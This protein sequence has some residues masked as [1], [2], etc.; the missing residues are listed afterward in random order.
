[1]SHRTAAS[2]QP[3]LAERVLLWSFALMVA[4]A[5]VAPVR[6]A[7]VMIDTLTIRLRDD[8]LPAGALRLSAAQRAALGAVLRNSVTENGRTRDGALRLTLAHPV[9]FMEA[10]AA[11]NRVR[12]QPEVLYASVTASDQAML[13]KAL[14]AAPANT[15]QPIT[16]MIVK[17]RDPAL[18]AASYRNGVLP[19]AALSRLAQAT[20]K[21]VAH[22]RA[23][24]GGAW[25][26]KLFQAV[27]MAE[28]QALA[29]LIE[30]DP[31]V[32]YAEPD[33]PMYPMLAPND[34]NFAV[35]Q[36]D[37]QPAGTSPGGANLPA[38]WDIT[39][40]SASIVVADLD[41]GILP[42]PDLAGRT[43]AGYDMISSSTTG[44]DGNGRDSDPTDPGDWVV[45]NECFSGSAASNSSWHGTHTAGTI[46]AAT[47]NAVGI[48]GVN[49]VSKI[50]AVRV[51]GKCCG[52]LADIADAIVWASGGSVAGAPDNATPARVINMS[53]GGSGVCGATYQNAINTALANG[54]VIAVSAGNGNTLTDNQRPANCS[55][56]ITVASVGRNGNRAYYSNYD[57]GAAP[58][59]VEIAAPGGEQSFSNDPNGVLSTLNAG[60]TVAAAYNYVYYQGTSMAAP[61]VTG[62][63]SLMLSANPALTP[64]QVLSK[65]QTSARAFPTGTVRDCTANLAAVTSTIKYCGAGIVDAA[66]AVL[67]A[68]GGAT[69]TTTTLGSSP[70]PSTFG[71][72]VTFTATV[73]GTN[74]TGTVNFKDGASSIAS[75]GAQTVSGAGNSRTAVCITSAL[76]VGTHSVTATYSG[77]A[78]NQTSTSAPPLSQVVNSAGGQTN[79]ALASVGAVAS[80]SST[81]N[82]NYPVAAVNNGDR[83]SASWGAGG[84]WND[85]TVGVFPDN[86]QIVFNG[87]KTID[88][89]IVYTLPDVPGPV[90]PTDSTTFS[91]YG[92]TAFTVQGWNGANWVTLGTVTGNNLVKRTVNFSAFTTDRIR[93]NVTNALNS[94][95]RIVEIEAF[96]MPAATQQ[97]NVA[98]ATLG[99]V[100][101][102]SSTYSAN[103]PVVAVNN[104]DRTGV[105]WGAGGGWNDA[106]IGVF[107][108]FVQIVFNGQKTIDHVIVYT[109]QDNFGSGLEPTNST[110]FSNYGVTAFDVQGWNGAS[111]V[112]L[113]TVTGNNLAKRTVNFSAFA[114]DRIRVN[115]NNAL[116]SYSRIVEIEAW[117]N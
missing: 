61:H 24:S 70:N 107:P 113:G 34:P 62:I 6:A 35:N 26:V 97:N 44:N 46:G 84:G 81:Y 39:T 93:I 14:A 109:L 102:A 16:Q 60:T 90:E 23:M 22:G 12:M 15:P 53:L 20:G 52:T 7:E 88:H 86:V 79:V 40:G 100:A 10:R 13:Q 98:S 77:D 28:A 36:W 48:A 19:P 58:T 99:G 104:D 18:T 55:G 96:G 42:H 91:L 67:S 33:A 115:V 47:N 116:N 71:A 59:Y 95:S 37:L 41:T 80:A 108:D 11:I 110:T 38:A 78:G 75:C 111:W 112:T 83:T 27:T 114:T 64:A 43:V 9:S 17:Y 51:L 66:A 94:Y 92:V 49:W 31:D 85:A 32:E 105:A 101:S 63:A 5:L 30:A 106:T 2:A 69:P 68:G 73:N 74:P 57:D 56:V 29:Q 117:G 103:Y 82:A 76:A 8:A 89:V 45:A 87:W 65:I 25:V 4:M 21:S 1:M 54:T 50:Q 3:N 72:S